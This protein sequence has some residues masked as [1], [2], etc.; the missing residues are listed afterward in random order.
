M[1]K[2]GLLALTVLTFTLAPPTAW[3]ATPPSEAAA[4]VVQKDDKG[5]IARVEA[6]NDVTEFDY[7]PAGRLQSKR[8]ERFGRTD[9]TY[10]PGSS[11][12]PFARL[13]SLRHDS[14]LGS[15]QRHL[16]Y[17]QDDQLALKFDGMD[18]ATVER[19]VDR[20]QPFYWP[21]GLK[22]RAIHQLD[23]VHGKDVASIDV[24]HD[25]S[26]VEVQ[27]SRVFGHDMEIT[28]RPL[29][30]GRVEVQ[31]DQGGQR[32]EIWSEGTLLNAYDAFGPLIETRLDALGRPDKVT[33]GGTT[34]LRF[35]YEGGGREWVRR[36][37]TRRLDDQVVGTFKRADDFDKL[38]EAPQPR[39]SA[40]AFLPGSA[41][42]AEWD[43]G[44]L[45]DGVVQVTR[46]GVPYALFPW[47]GDGEVWRSISTSFEGI[48]GQD[49]IDYTDSQVRIYLSQ[50]ASSLAAG[51]EAVIVIE[52]ERRFAP[53]REGGRQ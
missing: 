50:G 25:K 51:S 11:S 42:I 53:T 37:V 1:T 46:H 32:T 19:I 7:G 43:D 23:P 29:G 34:V 30:K 20:L 9:Y 39:R 3:A 28:T 6:A 27:R 49:R 17:D 12:G 24:I 31:D 14:D 35:E 18:D 36:H 21:K 40:L 8:S 26:G 47:S 52:R 15:W 44:L 33:V 48:A 4:K 41:P 2:Y 13:R 45:S 16:I 10:V 5:R 38:S 22:G